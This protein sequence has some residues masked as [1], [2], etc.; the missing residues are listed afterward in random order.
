MSNEKQKLHVD[1]TLCWC[2]PDVQSVDGLTN[3]IHKPEVSMQN[4][5][6]A[7]KDLH[8]YPTWGDV[9]ESNLRDSTEYT[10]T[11]LVKELIEATHAR[12][13]L[14]AYAMHGPDGIKRRA[15]VHSRYARA[16][17][18]IESMEGKTS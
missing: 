18:A 11:E 13:M 10:R 14:P 9:E 4:T 15:D 5:I 2:N 17:A 8:Y 12:I 6:W 1:S 7:G 3:I 16:L